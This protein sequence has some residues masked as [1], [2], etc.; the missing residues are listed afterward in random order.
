MIISLGQS[1]GLRKN[2][3]KLEI[4]KIVIHAHMHDLLKNSY[5]IEQEDLKECIIWIFY[6]KSVQ[7]S[8]TGKY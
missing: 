6:A 1:I 7:L 2:N 5:S 8:Y 4:I 3:I